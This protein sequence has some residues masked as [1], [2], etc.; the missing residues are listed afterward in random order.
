MGKAKVRPTRRLSYLM[1]AFPF[2][3]TGC[4]G[5]PVKVYNHTD[6]TVEVAFLHKYF[7]D[8]RDD[9]AAWQKVAIDQGQTEALGR[10]MYMDDIVEMRFRQAGR[11][12]PLATPL[13]GHAQKI[14]ERSGM[15]RLLTGGECYITYLGDGAIR[16]SA[17][18][19]QR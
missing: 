2:A 9:E 14:C 10:D 11:P 5:R 16:A 17:D 4:H 18:R 15:E 3:L 19:P 8:E 13:L 1:L 7:R 6:Q 12:F